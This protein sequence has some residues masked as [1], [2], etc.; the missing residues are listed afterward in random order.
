MARVKKV[1]EVTKFGGVDELGQVKTDLHKGIG[2]SVNTYDASTVEAKS[3]QTH[4][5]DDVGHGEAVIV[6]C[7]TFGMNPKTFLER[8]PTKQDLFNSHLRGIEMA[9]FGDGLKVFDEVP[10]RLVFDV[11]KQQYSI[12]VAARPR[13]GIMLYERP[14]TLREIING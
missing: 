8:K 11:K 9:L 3:E 13:K 12:F 1:K 14:Q 5:E 2:A 4:L 7:F 6:R 10:P